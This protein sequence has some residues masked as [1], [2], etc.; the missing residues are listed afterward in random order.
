MFMGIFIVGMALTAQ[1]QATRTWVSGVGDDVNPCSRTAPCKTWAGA[2]SKTA[3]GGEI[4]ALDPGG[5]GGLSITKAM[6]IDGAG[7]NASI[8][9]AGSNGISVSAATTDHVFIRNISINGAGT[10]FTGIRIL[11]A[12]S[13]TIENVTIFNFN[14]STNSRG[15]S[16]L[17]SSNDIKV[18]IL[19]TTIRHIAG[20]AIESIPS[21]TGTVKLSI[22]G[23]RISQ[24]GQSGIDL[25][26]NT[27]ANIS[28][29]TVVHNAVAG[30]FVERSSCVAN[31]YSTVFAQ[32]GQGLNV[33]QSGGGLI[34]LYGSQIAGNTIAGIQLTA[35]T[36]E[37]HQ[38]NAIR[39]NAGAEATSSNVGQQ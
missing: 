17:N 9:A 15:I 18:N 25:D 24:A 16:I 28:R 11:Q 39:G 2:I 29:S 10:G 3:A 35:G 1:G 21:G 14:S 7:T 22:D 13:V 38:N 30:L 23:S 34:R 19:N 36:V 27:V 32:N 12:A 5:F 8:L 33:G 31:V 37:T 4:D 6:T 20:M 26:N